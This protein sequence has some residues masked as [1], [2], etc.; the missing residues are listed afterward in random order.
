M[1][2]A[3]AAKAQKP[4]EAWVNAPVQMH[5]KIIRIPTLDKD[6]IKAR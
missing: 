5:P 4:V 2:P 3:L 6:W 1:E